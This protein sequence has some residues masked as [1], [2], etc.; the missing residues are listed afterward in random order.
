MGAYMPPNDM[1]A[2]YQV[3]QALA[4]K[5]PEIETILMGDLNARLEDPRNNSEDDLATSLAYHGL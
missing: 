2:V 4:A 1:P 5:P 3:D